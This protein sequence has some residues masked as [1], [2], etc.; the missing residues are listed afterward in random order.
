M[1][2]VG[3]LPAHPLD[4]PQRQRRHPVSGQR[5]Q[6]ERDRPSDQ[7]QGPKVAERLVAILEGGADDDDQL[8]VSRLHRRGE[9]AGLA[10]LH[11]GNGV[12]R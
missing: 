11:P 4:R 12:V 6:Q 2:I 8:P 9:Q 3:R 10:V 7:Q 5:R 1:E